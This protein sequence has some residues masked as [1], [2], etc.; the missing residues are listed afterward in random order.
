MAA[1]CP[2]DGRGRPLRSLWVLYRPETGGIS[3]VFLA[4]PDPATLRAPAGLV[5]GR[6]LVDVRVLQR[7][8]GCRVRDGRVVRRGAVATGAP[9]RET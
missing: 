3:T 6:F 9:S 5:L 8:G 7:I 1:P 2:R 4:A